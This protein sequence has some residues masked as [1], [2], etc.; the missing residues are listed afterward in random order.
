MTFT[1]KFLRALLPGPH[2]LAFLREPSTEGFAYFVRLA[3]L[4]GLVH[5]LLIVG[6]L[7]TNVRLFF[8]RVA[9]KVPAVTL[10]DGELVADFPAP[11]TIDL[12]DPRV[13]FNALLVL[14]PQGQ[15]ERPPLGPW[16]SFLVTRDRVAIQARGFLYQL[17]LASAFQW[18]TGVPLP[19]RPVTLD[20]AFWRYVRDRWVNRLTVLV[21]GFLLLYTL[22]TKFLQ[23]VL[24]SG[25]AM[26][27]DALWRLELEYAQLLNL[28]IYALTPMCVLG[29][30]LPLV[31]QWARTP[32]LGAALYYGLY[33]SI[34]A[35]VLW[36][37]RKAQ[38]TA[39]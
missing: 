29:I 4:T 26:V 5:W 1:R 2:Y 7:R 28:C 10:R 20:A 25:V 31:E 37:V 15:T 23:Y 6:P 18:L 22:M 32:Y 19:Q 34:V 38:I 8:D 16:V 11:R 3:L 35:V 24:A 30:V 27:L 13:P 39:A 14:D 9:Q 17:P 21:L 33:W 12:I 36:Q